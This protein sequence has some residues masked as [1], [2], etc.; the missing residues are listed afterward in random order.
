MLEGGNRGGES[1]LDQAVNSDIG[2]GN[3]NQFLVRKVAN[4]SE[5]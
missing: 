4:G 1:V 2:G 3:C 5:W